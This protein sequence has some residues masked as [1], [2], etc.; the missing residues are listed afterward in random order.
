VRATRIST[1]V[2]RDQ[3]QVRLRYLRFSKAELVDRL[4][5][6]ECAYA[7]QEQRW[8]ERQDEAL[9]WRL[10]AEAAETRLSALPKPIRI[11]Q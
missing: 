3:E 10:R 4:L 6:A 5:I 11:V 1:K 8:L 7:E 9:T 2:D